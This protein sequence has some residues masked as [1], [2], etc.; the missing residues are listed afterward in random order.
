MTEKTQTARIIVERDIEG[1]AWVEIVVPAKVAG[2]YET[3]EDRARNYVLAAMAAG[4]PLSWVTTLE[5]ESKVPERYKLTARNADE[6]AGA[7]EIAPRPGLAEV[8]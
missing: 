2:S 4:Q 1:T 3:P 5:P 7:P 6:E 8:E